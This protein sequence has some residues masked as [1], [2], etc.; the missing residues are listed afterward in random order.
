MNLVGEINSII[1]HFATGAGQIIYTASTLMTASG[2]LPDCAEFQ[3]GTGETSN[4][5]YGPISSLPSNLLTETFG[6]S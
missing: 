6:V 1:G 4:S 5:T 2:N 3:D